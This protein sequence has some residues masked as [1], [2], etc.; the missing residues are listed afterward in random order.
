M[1]ASMRPSLNPLRLWR[2][3]FA[4]MGRTARVE[5]IIYLLIWLIGA[6]V[7]FDL[8]VRFQPLPQWAEITGWCLAGALFV[9]LMGHAVRRLSDMGRR[10]WWAIVL[11][12]PLINLVFALWLAVSGSTDAPRRPSR[13]LRTVGMMGALAIAAVLVSRIWWQPAWIASAVMKPNLEPGDF[14]I[15]LN[16]V[17]KPTRADVVMFHHPR[18]GQPHISR[19]LGLPGEHFEMD[20]GIILIGEEPLEMECQGDV[21]EVKTPQGPARTALQC[22]DLDEGFIEHDKDFPKSWHSTKNGDL[23]SK[24]IH[25]EWT[26]T[27]RS[28]KVVEL[29]VI[30][31][32]SYAATTIPKGHYFMLG[33]NRDI[34]MD[35]RLPVEK[36][37]MGM[38]PQ[39]ALFASPRLVLFSARGDALWKFWTWRSDRFFKVIQ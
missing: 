30:P 39:S 21:H 35:S 34:S 23:C 18:T 22:I 26:E 13:G 25:E 29:G 38:V 31:Y 36:G 14:V 4:W 33:D 6:G 1:T 27:G 11:L 3:G 19:I 12:V 37:G 9:P 15:A 32:D 28:F 5:W 17:P 24:F 2:D 7:F 10:G 20:Y 16:R 8:R